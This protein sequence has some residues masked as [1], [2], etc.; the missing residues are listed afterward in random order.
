MNKI[1]KEIYE[2]GKIKYTP[3]I[4]T[5]MTLAL[6]SLQIFVGS[7]IP[8]VAIITFSIMFFIVEVFVKWLVNGILYMFMDIE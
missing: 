8:N 4:G 6:V 2:Q 5:L 3:Y 7:D 1:G